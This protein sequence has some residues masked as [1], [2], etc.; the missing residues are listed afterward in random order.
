MYMY[1]YIRLD[2]RR[3]GIP[4]IDHKRL[5]FHCTAQNMKFSMKDFFGKYDLSLEKSFMQNFISCAVFIR[6]QLEVY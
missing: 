6:I 3:Q 2:H 1:I 5:S 4:K